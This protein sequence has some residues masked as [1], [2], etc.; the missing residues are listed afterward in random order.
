[1]ILHA[2]ELSCVGPFRD[3]APLRLGPLDPRL[4]ILAAA[5]E[6][7]KST[8]IRAA[9]R[10]LFDRHTTRSD[11]IQ[12]LQPAGTDL[13]PRIAVEF[14]TRAGRFR[15]EK[16][17]L[18]SPRSLLQKWESGAWQDFAQGDGADQ[19]VQALLQSSLPGRGATKPEHWGFLGFLWAR[20]GEPTVW[21][22]LASST[23]GENIR[24]RLAQVEL[25]PVIEKLRATLGGTADALVTS[26]GLPKT[27]GHLSI[28]ETDLAE[29]ETE[30]AAL[31]RIRAELDSA[32][33]RYNQAVASVDQLETEHTGRERSASELR[34]QA[35][36][37]ERLRGE[38]QAR[39]QALATAQEKLTAVTTD[40]AA[41]AQRQLDISGA[42]T[43]L[44]LA[45]T[46]T[47]SSEARTTQL[48]TQL[49]KIQNDRVLHERHRQTQ[50]SELQRTQSL[51]KLR[52]FTT[53]AANLVGQLTKA[54][55]AS[56]NISTLETRKSSLPALTPAKLR[57]IETLAESAHTLR[58]Q[59][60]SIGLT[61]ELTPK[62]AA[63]IQVNEGTGPRL[64]PLPARKVTSVQS[65]QTLDFDLANWGHIVIR[66]GA[67]ETQDV[68]VSLAKAEA[69]MQSAL[70][71]AAVTSVSE[72]RQAI[73]DRKELDVQLNAARATLATHLGDYESLTDLRDAAAAA[74]Q[75]AEALNSKFQPTADEVTLSHTEL[76]STEAR[77]LAAVPAAESDV[78]AIDDQLA[79]IRT[80]DRVATKALQDANQLAHEHNLRLSALESQIEALLARY[81]NSLETAKTAAQIE[82]AQ[83]EA[84][85]SATKAE[86]PPDFEKLPER[87][88]RAATAL[89]EIANDLQAR[90][91]ERDQ[92][93]GTLESLGGQGLYSRETEFE[94][95]KAEAILRRDAFRAQAWTA[96][97]AH[98]L[99]E[100]RKQAATKAVLAPL[101]LRLTTALAGL[102][103]DSARQ[104]FL[105]EN[106]QIVGLGR[107]RNEAYPF[108]SLSQG[109]KEQLLLCL[110]IAVAQELANDEPQVLILDDVLVN[111]DSVRQER[112]LDVLGSLSGQLQI[113]I[114]TCHPD[115]YRGTGVAINFSK[116]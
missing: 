79:N 94:E 28:A 106:L 84:R 109:T 97:L 29:I 112:V 95:K 16:T 81:P 4:N 18:Q 105:D 1:M 62:R 7:G 103:G 34:E 37:T 88:R 47:Q 71:Q 111:T 86:L 3:A 68:A 6:A 30:L 38:L 100:N 49:D 85:V 39:R 53:D 61:V 25:D 92:A 98:D 31:R 44:A 54:D 73:A 101:E 57:K 107:A 87:N 77:L 5:N 33:Q 80:E 66:S 48:R 104:V 46:T 102:T 72:A 96:R 43:A 67:Q 113:V 83:A 45:E 10:A 8:S 99:I 89:Q 115:R 14:E 15:I 65:P 35:L 17:F 70:E 75:R 90:R 76:E 116:I 64:V 74:N 22:S 11:E 21:P 24:A 50:H 20:Q 60:Q 40:T 108:D 42:R 9:A 114:L 36:A 51:L 23:V 27:N 26:K 93:K 91:T 59:L 32:L 82:F 52:Q 110:R 12:S 58:A 63:S 78:Q 2:I 55:T 69:D 56:A 41:L 19:R 13:A